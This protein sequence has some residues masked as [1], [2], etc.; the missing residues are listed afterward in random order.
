M[1]T[2]NSKIAELAHHLERRAP[3][4]LLTHSLMPHPLIPHTGAWQTP[5]NEKTASPAVV[6]SAPSGA[7]QASC[8]D[9]G[10]GKADP[11]I[12]PAPAA[13]ATA[14]SSAWAQRQWKAARVAG[15]SHWDRG[16]GAA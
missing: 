13:T 14:A 12:C 9:A 2:Q 7:P 4:P 16:M 11:F 10:L 3:T 5:A 1:H 15:T 6:V 8:G